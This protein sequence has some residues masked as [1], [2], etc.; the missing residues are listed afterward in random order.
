MFEPRP[1]ASVLAK[2]FYARM[3]RERRFQSAVRRVTTAIFFA[4]DPAVYGCSKTIDENISY[5]G[6]AFRGPDS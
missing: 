6:A 3:I 2:I 4:L 1:L 5:G